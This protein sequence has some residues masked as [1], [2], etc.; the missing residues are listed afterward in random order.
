LRG[1]ACH[2][3]RWT[4]A[5]SHRVGE[6]E[7]VTPDE[8]IRQIVEP[9]IKEMVANRSSMR[10]AFVACLATFHTLDYLAGNRRRAVVRGEY[11]R[12][13]P[14]FA[15][16][17][18]IAHAG[19]GKQSGDRRP[20]TGA[21]ARPFP[22]DERSFAM[23]AFAGLGG[24]PG[25]QWMQACRLVNAA[26][27]FLKNKIRELDSQQ[28]QPTNDTYYVVIPFDRNADGDVRAGRAQEAIS[29]VAAERRA[30]ALAAEHIGALAF[31][32]RGDPVTGDF[33]DPVVLAQFGEVDLSALGG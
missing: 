24:A 13:S 12:L 1:V 9:T 28:D 6:G 27:E 16:I 3:K 31:S 30:R 2:V 7:R 33:E 26:A 4:G 15:A 18:R 29:A 23:D 10:H 5:E 17:D 21:H 19:G 8:Y 11:R 20:R 14:A 32:R 25:D 22:G